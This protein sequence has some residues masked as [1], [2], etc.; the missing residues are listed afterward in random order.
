MAV[1]SFTV[2]PDELPRQCNTVP[3]VEPAPNAVSPFETPIRDVPSY[4]VS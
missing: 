2:D 3:F 1:L 4:T